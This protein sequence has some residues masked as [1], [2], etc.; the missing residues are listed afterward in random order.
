MEPIQLAFAT[1]AFDGESLGELDVKG[2]CA[3]SVF[4]LRTHNAAPSAPGTRAE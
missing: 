4:G 3:I 2:K 1:S